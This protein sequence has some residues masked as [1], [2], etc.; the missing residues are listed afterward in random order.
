MT[1]QKYPKL[2]DF[3]IPPSSS[4]CCSFGFLCGETT[5]N[6]EKQLETKKNN[7]KQRETGQEQ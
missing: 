2:C 3:V 7:E 5:R 6:N 4:D 1:S